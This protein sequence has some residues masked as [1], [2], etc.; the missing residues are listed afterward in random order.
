MAAVEGLLRQLLPASGFDTTSSLESLV[1]QRELLGMVGVI[2][3]L[4]FGTFLFDAVRYVLN[5]VFRVTRKRPILKAFGADAMVMFAMGSLLGLTMV[6]TSVLEVTRDLGARVAWIAP[7]LESGWVLVGRGVGFAL[8]GAM[9]Y[10]LYRV[11]PAETLSRRALLVAAFT[12][13]CLFEIS[14]S[15]F[16]LYMDQARDFTVF[17][18]A[19]SGVIFFVL[20][21]YYASAVF[22][23][24]AALGR[25]YESAR[26][27]D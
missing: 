6:V 13:A 9:L 4:L 21:I 5:I 15:L 16:G 19:L 7:F 14:K 3:F 8:T 26:S 20:W 24:A 17:Y 2:L 10:L 22:T 1:Y 11:A 23:L 25:G 18:G 27:S 12:G